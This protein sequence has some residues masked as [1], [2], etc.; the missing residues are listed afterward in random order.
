MLRLAARELGVAPAAFWALSLAEWRA[1]AGE[2]AA[3]VLGREG[4]Q[5]LL[6]GHPD[7]EVSR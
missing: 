4:L 2:H 6:D 5:R 1:L 7:D 3:P